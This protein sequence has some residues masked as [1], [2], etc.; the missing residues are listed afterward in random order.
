MESVVDTRASFPG[1]ELAFD[2]FIIKR[3]TVSPSTVNL[4]PT[5]VWDHFG[6]VIRL[7]TLKQ[8]LII[9]LTIQCYVHTEFRIVNV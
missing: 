5:E 3:L 7:Y 4:S 1:G 6:L 8:Y 9:I 2:Q